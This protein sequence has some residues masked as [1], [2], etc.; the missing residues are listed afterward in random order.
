MAWKKISH[1]HRLGKIKVPVLVYAGEH[2]NVISMKH[3]KQKISDKIKRSLLLPA[4][5]S[6][7][8]IPLEMAELA[9]TLNHWCRTLGNL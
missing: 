3:L 1:S 9:E 4:R 6:G 8:L 5:N 2:D 7:H